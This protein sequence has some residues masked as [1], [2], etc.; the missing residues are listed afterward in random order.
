MLITHISFQKD[1][2]DI[3]DG[4]IFRNKWCITLLIL[5][6]NN[7][8][9][10]ISTNAHIHML[11]MAFSQCYKISRT[12]E[13]GH[14]SIKNPHLDKFD[15]LT[16]YTKFRCDVHEWFCNI[17]ITDAKPVS[18]VIVDNLYVSSLVD[19]SGASICTSPM[20]WNWGMG[21]SFVLIKRY[22]AL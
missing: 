1:F 6:W 12:Y 18:Q 7:T 14:T 13:F 4:I 5:I 17:A 11:Y 10:Y 22:N 8:N 19:G 21:I 16:W 3:Y 20:E 2:N 9:V 15:L